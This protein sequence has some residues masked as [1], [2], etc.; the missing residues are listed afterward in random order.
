V[1]RTGE[2]AR[3]VNYV[4]ATAANT[5]YA[6]GAPLQTSTPSSSAGPADSLW[7][8]RTGVGNG[9]SVLASNESGAENAP[10]LKTTVSGLAAGT[11][12][13]F[14]YFWSDNDED[15]R[16]L[17]GLDSANLIDFRRFGSQYDEAGQFASIETTSA[18]SN[19]LLLYRA[20][21][22]RAQVADGGS[23]TAYI[24]DWQ[25]T[26][27]AIRTWYDGLGYAPVDAVSPLP[28][29]F[30]SNR[31]VDAY[32]LAR[33]RDEFGSTGV[34]D[35]DGDGDS[36]GNDFLVW[37]RQLGATAARPAEEAIPEPGAGLLLLIGGTIVARR[38]RQAQRQPRKQLS[39]SC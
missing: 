36:D 23:I 20:Y 2:A 22:G 34:A 4:D 10:Q 12:D 26:G 35:A 28:G 19:D 3:L 13:L 37:Q 31:V 18:N 8:L 1:E 39:Q 38:A 25:S 30:D 14:A 32:D 17:A 9:G 33:W 29:D 15:W 11:Y 21:L 7:H 5:T 16:L 27:T 24:D 6:S